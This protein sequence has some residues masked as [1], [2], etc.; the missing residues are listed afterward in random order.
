MI[1]TLIGTY[2]AD[3][4]ARQTTGVAVD[5]AADLWEDCRHYIAEARREELNGAR[6]FQAVNRAIRGAV[7]ALCSHLEGVVS[8]VHRS[9][10][11][12]TRFVCQRSSNGRESSLCDKIRDFRNDAKHRLGTALPYLEL[13]LKLLRDI[14]AH[15]GITKPMRLPRHIKIMSFPGGQSELQLVDNRV[16]SEVDLYFLTIDEVE[17]DAEA[18]NHWLDRLCGLYQYSR[19]PDTKHALEVALRPYGGAD[20]AIHKI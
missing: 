11:D 6:S 5:L 3:G 8:G 10:Q 15:P 9:L 13:K 7:F 18:I 1:V 16:L 4:S 20:S 17:N 14:L 2:P 19:F 12:D